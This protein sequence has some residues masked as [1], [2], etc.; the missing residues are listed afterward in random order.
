MIKSQCS[1]EGCSTQ[2][3]FKFW[4][5][6]HNETIPHWH[7]VN[8]LDA[9]QPTT[10]IWD[11]GSHYVGCKWRLLHFFH[12]QEVFV[13]PFIQSWGV[14]WYS[15]W[16]GTQFSS[17]Y[18][19]AVHWICPWGIVHNNEMLFL[20]LNQREVLLNMNICLRL[21][22]SSQCPRNRWAIHRYHLVWGN[23]EHL[24]ICNETLESAVQ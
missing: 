21:I 3:Y 12:L 5:I 24:Y 18:M 20:P 22:L 16:C 19:H 13:L 8:C 15:Q 23:A 17:S 9:C 10:A 14:V 4:H 6:S 1:V 7:L 11:R 2:Q